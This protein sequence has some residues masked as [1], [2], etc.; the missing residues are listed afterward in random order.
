MKT[1]LLAPAG[2]YETM[3]AAIAAGADAVYIGGGRFGARAYA[4]NPGEDRLLAAIDYV[5]LHRKKLYLTVNTLLKDAELQEELYSYLAPL[6]REGLDA[7][8]VQDLGV[9][10]FIKQNF[11]RLPIHAST[12]MTITGPEGAAMLKE[13]G[14]V[15][16]VTAR[17]LSLEEIRAIRDATHME[18]ESFVHG[19]LC[20]CYSGQCLMSSL[21]GGRSGNRGRCAQPCRLPYQVW[22]EDR[23]LNGQDSSYP[24]SPKDMCTIRLLPQI[25][26]AGVTSLKI[27]GRMKKAEYTAGVVEIYRKY[28]DSCLSGDKRFRVSREDYQ[29]LLDLYNRDG[30]HESYYRQRNGKNMMALRNEKNTAARKPARNEA[31]FERIRRD[32][33]ERKLQEGVDGWLWLEAGEQ[34][35]L[36]LSAGQTQVT[37]H[38][39]MVQEAVNRPLQKEQ[40]LRQMKKTGGT[41]FFF[42]NLEI[43]VKGNIFMPMQQL[44]SL[45]RKGME[46]LREEILRGFFRTDEKA[47]GAVPAGSEKAKNVSQ[48]LPFSVS[49]ATGAQLEAVL[50]VDGIEAVYADCGIFPREMFADQ[51]KKTI[52][53]A[54]AAGKRLYLAL[55]WVVRDRELDGRA[56]T[57]GQLVREGLAGFLVRNLESL[58][59]L[60]RMGLAYCCRTDANVYTMNGEARQFFLDEGCAGDT[61]PLELNRKE[62]G[63]RDNRNSEMVV[64]GYLPMMISAQCLKKN[65]DACDG[66]C[67]VLTVKDR[68]MK[69]FHAVCSCEFCYNIL[70]N[71]VPLSLLE[72]KAA[73]DGLGC[74][75]YRLAF[76]LEDA[77]TTRRTAET[78]VSVWRKGRKE[79]LAGP[80]ETTRGHFARGVE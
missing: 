18:I 40:I 24:L 76:T 41:D 70:Y 43:A 30:F 44:N 74:G 26:E 56:E 7:V 53:R 22:Q 46:A 69:E 32:Y 31:L 37:V 58:A 54:E 23:R 62:L 59:I 34:A 21:I 20:Y 11:P 71:T 67:A 77:D 8:I 3:E 50:A 36:S 79:R 55:P 63:R 1:E 10:R 73:L 65:L 47:R 64:Y 80:G 13:A 42:D 49:V 9:L 45:R 38:G 28:L 5:H 57:F 78:F 25:I 33:L 16:V 39:E 68:Y 15:R 48:M 66:K 52:Q 4:D 72:E 12:Q 35:V 75:G 27:E 2:S 29:Q 51:V 19:A 17:E 61:V 60:K 14:A 6:Y